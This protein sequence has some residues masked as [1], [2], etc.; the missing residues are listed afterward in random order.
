MEFNSQEEGQ[1]AQAIAELSR[2][3]RRH[4][5]SVERVRAEALKQ[6]APA[7][8]FKLPTVA[9]L[10]ERHDGTDWESF[11]T[12][13]VSNWAADFFDQGLAVWSAAS[14]DADPWTSYRQVAGTLQVTLRHAQQRI[15]RHK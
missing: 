14:P 7:E 4:V 11:I 13:A 8:L 2:H 3:G 10:A 15:D 12:G 6:E 9:S 5:T 1:W